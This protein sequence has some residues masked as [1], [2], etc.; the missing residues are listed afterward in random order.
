MDLKR[1]AREI[2]LFETA[3]NLAKVCDSN[4]VIQKVGAAMPL[5]DDDIED[6][7]DQAARWLIGFNKQ[8]YFFLTPEIALIDA[9]SKNAGEN[10]E[11]IVAVPCD[12]DSDQKERLINNLPKNLN[13][14]TWEEPYFLQSFFPANGMIV[15]CGYLGNNRA[16]VLPD[17]Y[18]MF[19][20][21][22]RF[23]G[24]KVFLPY[25]E[26]DTAIRFDDWIEISQIKLTN[27]W[28]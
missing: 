12:L 27:E 25:K 18:R 11:I 4:D 28:R 26:L 14:V 7:V 8:K 6:R 5:P 16:M 2:G 23:L 17:T 3:I 13:V 10:T 22:S 1:T 21:Y 15:I 24:K 20:H 9:M 19:E